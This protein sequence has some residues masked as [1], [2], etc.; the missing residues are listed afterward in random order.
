MRSLAR[1]EEHEHERAD[2]ALSNQNAKE[3]LSAELIPNMRS[4]LAQK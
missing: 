1:E 4:S 3:T 2:Q